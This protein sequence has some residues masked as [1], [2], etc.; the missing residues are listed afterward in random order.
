MPF[1]NVISS[2]WSPL[3]GAVRSAF[4]FPSAAIM[5]SRQAN[6]GD[7]FRRLFKTGV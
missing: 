4:A 3:A 1:T 7:D 5:K 6:G 2:R